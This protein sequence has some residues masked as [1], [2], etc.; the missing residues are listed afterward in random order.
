MEELFHLYLGLVELLKDRFNVAD[1][2]IVWSLI[3]GNS[4][5]PVARQRAWLKLSFKAGKRA[6]TTHLWFC[7]LTRSRPKHKGLRCMQPSSLL[8]PEILPLLSLA[9]SLNKGD[10][11][12]LCH[13]T[14]TLHT[15]EGNRRKMA[16][17]SQWLS[18]GDWLAIPFHATGWPAPAYP[19]TKVGDAV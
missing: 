2:A 4:R 14:V 16:L 11:L 18:W 13:D 7:V 6:R 15:W 9:Q 8:L 5:V 19:H 12:F 10:H 1:G 17:Q 3:V